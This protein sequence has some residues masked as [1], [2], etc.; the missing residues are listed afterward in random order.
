LEPLDLAFEPFDDLARVLFVLALDFEL[1]E[2][3]REER[4]EA[5]FR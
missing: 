2:D 5:D 3:A 1:A 4:A